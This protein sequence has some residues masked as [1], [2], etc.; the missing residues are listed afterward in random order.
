MPAPARAPGLPEACAALLGLGWIG[1]QFPGPLALLDNLSN[2]PAHFAF[3]LLAC[4]AWLAARRRFA[5]AAG[6]LVLAALA[7]APAIPWYQGPEQAPADGSRPSIELLVSNVY[8]ANSQYDRIQRLIAAEDPDVVGLIEVDSRW[9]RK[10]AALRERYPHHF[11]MEDERHVGLALYS[12]LPLEDA[13]VLQ[14]PGERSTPAIAA[15][16]VAPGSRKAEIVLVHT[17]PPLS[18]HLIRRRNEQLVALA[19][20]ARAQ[21]GPV[22]MAGDFNVTMWNDGYRPLAEIAGLRNARSGYGIG[23]SWPPFGPLGVPIDHVLATP[24]VGLGNFDVLPAI[25]SDHLPVSAHVVLPRE[26]GD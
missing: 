3:A 10:L 6:S 15:T 13:R 8:Y 23:P 18:A 25:G 19:R 26:P 4:A 17:I 22:V 21:S 7:I 14:L 16:L 5:F 9:L 2:F 11:E 20:Y 24:D 12:R 1:S